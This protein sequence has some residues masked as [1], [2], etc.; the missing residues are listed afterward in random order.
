MI[1]FLGL[2][3]AIYSFGRGALAAEVEGVTKDK[4]IIGNISPLTGPIAMVGTSIANGARDYFNYINEQGGINGRKI[5]FIAEDDKYEPS[6]AIASLKKL[7]TRDNIFALSST[8]GTPITAA[9]SPTIEKEKLPSMSTIAAGIIFQPKPPR[10]LFSFGAFYSENMVYNIEYALF[11]LKAK[12]PKIAFFYQDDDFGQ[13]GYVGFKAAVEKYKL[14]VVAVEK[15]TRGAIDISSQVFNIKKSNPDYVFLSLVPSHT[16]LFLKEAKKVGL[17]VPAIA[18][19]NERFE[20]IIEVCGDAA[21]NFYCSEYTALPNETNVPGMAKLMAIWHKNNPPDKV[22]TRY[23]IISQVNAMIMAEAMKRGGKDLN[24][25]KFRDAIES[26]KDF[27][28]EGITEKIS[29]AP[30]DH[31]PLTAMRMVKANPKTNRYEVVSDWG[32]TRF[33]VRRK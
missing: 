29:Y 32:M 27:N 24:R 2:I 30:N 10:Y 33:E 22:P 7:I 15:H 6:T 9:L 23:Y 5:E 26:L 25:E 18:V 16:I 12:S 20:Q 17:N 4:I 13:E 21:E 28:P 11:T 14:N 1:C 3:I 19:A 31:C 8:S